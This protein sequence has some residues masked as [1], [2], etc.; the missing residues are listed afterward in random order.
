MYFT[1]LNLLQEYLVDS[2]TLV[3][4]LCEIRALSTWRWR[5]S[6]VAHEEEY[7]FTGRRIKEVD[8]FNPSRAASLRSPPGTGNKIAQI[9]VVQFGFSG[10]RVTLVLRLRVRLAQENYK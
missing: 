10:R 9:L 4:E 6:A 2:V 3:G 1:S 8:W 5:L 7:Q